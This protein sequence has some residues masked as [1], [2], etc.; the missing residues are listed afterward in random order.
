[1]DL[2]LLDMFCL[3]FCFFNQHRRRATPMLDSFLVVK[4]DA[5]RIGNSR[6]KVGDAH[7][8]PNLRCEVGDVHHMHLP[9]GFGHVSTLPFLRSG[10]RI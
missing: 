5:R 6:C 4:G 3:F 2:E 1:M 10:L 8:M 7:S 9:F